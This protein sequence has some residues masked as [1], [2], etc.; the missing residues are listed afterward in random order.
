MIDRDLESRI[1]QEIVYP[2][3]DELAKNGNSYVGILGI[4]IIIDRNGKLNV[5]EFNPFF[6]EPDA[7]C[8]LELLDVNL[9]NV[10]RAAIVGSLV[11]EFNELKSLPLYSSAVVLSSGNYPSDSKYGHVISGLEESEEYS[12]ISHF[13]TINNGTDFI[14]CGGRTLVVSSSAS[15]LEKSVQK[16]YDSVNLISFDDKKYR[17]DIGKTLI[18]GC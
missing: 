13:N 12:S 6:K 7:Q 9:L 2:T 1:F 4:D 14:T 3:L 18:V 11:D 10:M 5:L 16:T 8:I 17:K 15:T